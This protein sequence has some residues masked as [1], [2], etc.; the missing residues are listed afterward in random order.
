MS[1]ASPAP[2]SLPLQGLH[3]S[4]LS[5]APANCLSTSL[6]MSS[7]VPFLS[8][9]F[10]GS[11]PLWQYSFHFPSLSLPSSGFIHVV[12]CPVLTCCHIWHCV[13][14][15]VL[16]GSVRCIQHAQRL[17][18]K[19]PGMLKWC[20]QF[21]KLKPPLFYPSAFIAICL[22]CTFTVLLLCI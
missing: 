6:E 22:N 2:V 16:S 14:A 17:E 10:F 1:V 19:M 15:P 8:H 13:A 11:F 4:V 3:Y 12:L 18:G 21:V 20:T 7:L 9:M 5:F